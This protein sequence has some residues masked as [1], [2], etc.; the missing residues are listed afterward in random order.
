[1]SEC[2]MSEIPSAVIRSA[3]HESVVKKLKSKKYRI[4]ISSASHAGANNFM[5]SIYRVSFSKEDDNEEEQNPIHKMIV[6]VSP[7]QLAR[8]EQ[9][10]SR[11]SF[12][13]EIYMYEKVIY[14]YEEV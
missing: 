2:D 1:M 13:R 4:D 11:A 14:K 9:F 7:Q 8:R 3:L 5:G 10:F 12:L 6:K